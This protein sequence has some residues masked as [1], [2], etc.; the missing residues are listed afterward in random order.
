MQY[1]SHAAM[2]KKF[3]LESKLKLRLKF[4]STSSLSQV[5]V[6]V[7]T[8]QYNKAVLVSDAHTTRT[9]LFFQYCQLE[10]NTCVDVREHHTVQQYV[11]Y[12]ERS[13]RQN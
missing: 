9:N 11:R 6:Q 12:P 4:K 2:G 1:V 7:T 10:T 5:E 8:I 13:K 3:T